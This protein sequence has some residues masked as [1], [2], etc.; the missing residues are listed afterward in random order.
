[1]SLEYHNDKLQF[2]GQDV[3]SLA[4]RFGTPLIIYDEAHMRGMM[5]SYHTVL[6]SHVEHY[7]VSYASKAFTSLQMIQLLKEED[8]EIDVVS[9]G[10]L[11]TAIKGGIDPGKIKFHGNNKTPEELEFA[12]AQGVTLFIIDSLDEIALL[13]D[14]ADSPVNVLLRV[15]PGVDVDTHEFI[16][17][18]QTDS[19]FGLSIA[20]GTALKAVKEMEKVENLDFKGIH[21]HLGSQ[22][23]DPAPFVNALTAVYDWLN[24]H[25][26]EIE[27]L[28]MGGGFGV[29]YTDEDIRF[30]VEEGFDEIFTRLKEVTS[31]YGFSMPH[32]IIEPGRSITAEAAITVYEV[33]TVKDIPGVSRYVSVNGGMSDHI[34]TPLYGAEYDII[35]VKQRPDDSGDTLANVV[36]KLCE[37]GDIIGKNKPLP[38]NIKRGDLV[39]VK[40]TGAYHYSMA[41]N[42]NQMLKPAVVFI[43]A[44]GVKEVIKRQTLDQL[45]Q[46]DVLM[47][48]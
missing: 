24:D 20:D 32:V 42:Y 12:L 4:E 14:I 30:P 26:I 36:G 39:A 10:E 40:T 37:S 13:D 25:G 27:I 31:Q 35:P 22:L 7:S 38:A 23:S 21:Y 11:Y 19:K 47:E 41:S 8:M 16:S 3:T 48:Y 17:T 33:G 29:R 2:G 46:N 9:S 28:N 45:I 43:A 34:R 15:N 18:G 6:S 1:M 44:D 5:R